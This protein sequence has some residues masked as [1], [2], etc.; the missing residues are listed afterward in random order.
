MP[1]KRLR[2]RDPV[3]PWALTAVVVS[4]S[5]HALVWIAARMLVQVDL[6]LAFEETRIQ[7]GLALSW[8]IAS[9]AF[10]SLF[11]PQNR[12]SAFLSSL[13]CVVLLALLGSLIAYV[14]VHLS[15]GLELNIANILVFSFYSLLMLLAQALLAIPALL[16]LQALSLT[17]VNSV[18]TIQDS[19]L[20]PN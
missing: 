2:L 20:N 4:L 6:D 1:D 7:F 14:R 15:E 13:F 16:S 9:L 8:L 5:L 18:H 17:S 12:V 11:P 3:L 10:W 19:S